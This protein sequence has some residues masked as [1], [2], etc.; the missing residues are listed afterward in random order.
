MAEGSTKLLK[1][2]NEADWLLRPHVH[3]KDPEQV[4]E[5][6]NSMIQG[7][8]KQL[9]V[10]FDFD[11]T[12]TKHHENGVITHSSYG[13]LETVPTFPQS[14]RESNRTKLA[15]YR[16]IEIDPNI[17]MEEKIP[18]MLEWWTSGIEDMKGIQWDLDMVEKH[19]RDNQQPF[20][21]GTK[22]C[23]EQLQNAGVPVL[24]FSA[25]LGDVVRIALTHKGLLTSNVHIISNFLK[26]EDGKIAGYI[27]ENL[28]HVFNKNEAH[29][30]NTPYYEELTG[31]TNVVLLGDSTGDAMMA[32]GVSH[33]NV[34]KIGFLNTDI[35]Q[36]LTQF[37]DLF[38]I[39]LTDDQTMDVLNHILKFVL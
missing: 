26:I 17:T 22:A 12:L 20:R 9:Q 13:V 34:L 27:G 16:P 39:V 11:R 28:I 38:D 31:R 25:G 23:F 8:S 1:S 35:E 2:I 29:V 21:D 6:I 3:M 32:D 24:V 33:N 5:K 10:V 18:I 14:F 7:G 37:K 36:C 4:I 30:K 19:L 15:K